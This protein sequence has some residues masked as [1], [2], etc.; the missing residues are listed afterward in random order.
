MLIRNYIVTAWRMVRRSPLFTIINISGLALGLACS[1]LIFLW[2]FEEI[3][4]DRFHENGKRIFRINSV[5][6]ENPEV[7]WINSPFPLAPAL[8]DTYPFIEE[9]TRKWQY[10][11]IVR[12]EEKSTFEDNGMLVDP[13]FFRMYSYPVIQGQNAHLLD[14]RQ[15]IVLTESLSRRL[16][17]EEED[18][19][20]KIILLNEN[21]PLTISGIISDPPRRSEFQ[22]TFLASIELL[23]PERLSS[24]SMDVVSFIMIDRQFPREEAQDQLKDFYKTV[25][26][27]STAMIRIQPLANIHLREAGN[28]GLSLY[29]RLFGAVAILILVVA[30]INYMN[31][32]TVRSVDRAREISIR[33]ITGAKPRDI[34]SQFYLEPALITLIALFLAFIMLEL[35]RLP[36]NSLTGKNILLDY[37][38]PSLW[39]ILG[40]V[41]LMT[42]LLS[43]IYPAIQSG[44]FNP[45]Q[46]LSRRFNPRKGNLILRSALVVFQFAISTVL[47][48]AAITFARQLQYINHRDA[49]YDK[50]NLLV[51]RFGPPFTDEFDLIK[52]KILENPHI[53]SVTGSS[54]LPSDVTW[55]VSLD[56]EG[57]QTGEPIPIKYLMVDYDFFKTMGMDLVEGR[58]FSREY[59]TDDSIAYIVNETAV[60]EMQMKDPVG[61]TV[62][63]IHPDFP[64]GLR[65][66]TIIGIVKDFHAGTFQHRIPPVVLRMYRP[67]YGFLILKI[68]PV[69][70][71]STIAYLGGL[72]EQLA[73]GYPFEYMFFEDTWDKLY[74]SEHQLNCL[75]R[76]FALLAIVIS[77]LGVLGLSTYS[78][79]RRTKE[80]GIRKV[81]GARSR[82]IMRLLVFDTIRYVLISVS[83]A[84]PVGWF[85]MDR[86]LRNY[87]YRIE[88]TWWTFLAAAVTALAISFLTTTVQAYRQATKNPSRSLRY[89]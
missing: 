69:D 33:K 62:S 14:N 17:G 41:Y 29:L 30:C 16:F 32:S 13:G 61:K 78:A 19:V 23:P 22:F 81:N 49:G 83:I 8:S 51:V 47:V 27:T 77:S 39:L 89:E 72:V 64:E 3:G 48:I 73:P 58:S 38:D 1:L 82:E 34:R 68:D 70:I 85:I 80:I 54:L 10:P 5:F 50:K 21:T 86:W 18:P 2:I 43:G 75:I 79:L 66:G 63:F 53:L 12:Y 74:R 56:W 60:S 31:L 45:V 46:I 59:P 20:G 55:Q 7:V 57:N 15:Q 87:V 67:W 4:Y 24:P 36:F 9:F 88:I 52:E 65:N 35:F 76:I 71:P 6:E 40:G 26:S 42:V 28:S 37:H 25:D 11:A 44:K 84:I